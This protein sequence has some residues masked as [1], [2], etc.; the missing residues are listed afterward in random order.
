MQIPF[1]MGWLDMGSE[2]EIDSPAKIPKRQEKYTCYPEGLTEECVYL[3]NLCG[4]L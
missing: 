3:L 1:L 4:H 2:P